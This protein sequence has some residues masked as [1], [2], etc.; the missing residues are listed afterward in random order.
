L[1]IVTANANDTPQPEPL[2]PWWSFGKTVLA[3][4][5]LRLVDLQRLSLDA[6]IAG[7]GYTLRHLL[8]HTSG[9]RDYGQFAEYHAAVAANETPWSVDELLRRTNATPLFPIGQRFSYSNIGYLFVR[10]M[11]ERATGS[12][13]ET[14]LRTLVFDPLGVVGVFVASTVAEFDRVTWRNARRYDPRWVYQ[15]CVV[16]SVSWAATFLHR[17]MHG[18]LLAPPAKAAMLQLVPY[19]GDFVEASNFGYGL[20]VMCEQDG[21]ERRAIGHAG[22]GPGST[23]VVFSFID[24]KTPVTLAAASD[25]DEQNA[26][27]KLIEH[28][29]TE[30]GG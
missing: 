10:Q 25:I 19:G 8:Q 22:S 15:G 3:A 1:G 2:V 9:L 20:G 18:D 28:L 16:G 21:G 7:A 4:A 30:A 29:K 5:A 11:I 26:F 13:L 14:A 6:P 24:R 17:L 23:T 12:D 27:I